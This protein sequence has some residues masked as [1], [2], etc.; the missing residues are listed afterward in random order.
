M[1]STVAFCASHDRDSQIGKDIKCLVFDDFKNSPPPACN[2][3][4]E[5]CILKAADSLHVARGPLSRNSTGA[6]DNWTGVWRPFD[7]NRFYPYVHRTRL[8]RT[9]NDVFMLINK[10]P[11]IVTEDNVAG[12]LELNGRA[13]SGAFHPTAEAHAIIGAMIMNSIPTQIR[14]A[15]KPN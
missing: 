5:N 12:I 7:A 9:P 6:E 13:T 4:G 3:D 10:R 14:G 11:S 1:E 8:F 15:D 2:T